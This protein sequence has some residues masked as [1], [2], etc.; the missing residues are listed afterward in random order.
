MKPEM[1]INSGQMEKAF[2]AISPKGLRAATRAA[3]RNSANVIKRAVAA[4]YKSAYP[5]S[6]RYKAIHMVAYKQGDGAV[7][8]LQW[9]KSKY[10]EVRPYV[11]RFQNVGS[12]GQSRQTEAG[13]NRGVMPASHFFSK[14]V[15]TSSNAAAAR[16]EA[17]IAKQLVNRA[18]KEGFDV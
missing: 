11:M 13:H 15:A 14:G 3:F 16:L 1:T 10:K 9:M 4:E 12:R 2:E 6:Q 8:D 5:G 7:V 17:E 18:R